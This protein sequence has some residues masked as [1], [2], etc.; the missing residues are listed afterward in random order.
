MW[1]II[2]SLTLT[3]SYVY[4]YSQILYA[5]ENCQYFS[6]VHVYNTSTIIERIIEYVLWLFPIIFVFWP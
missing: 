4:L 2:V 1:I 6:N 5:N 3:N